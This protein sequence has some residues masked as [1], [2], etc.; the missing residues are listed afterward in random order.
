[1]LF[2][3]NLGKKLHYQKQDTYIICKKVKKVNLKK[4]HLDILIYV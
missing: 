2:L 1:M 3:H 4:L